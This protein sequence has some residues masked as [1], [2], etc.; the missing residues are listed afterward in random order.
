MKRYSIANGELPGGCILDPY[1]IHKHV[2][3][4]KRGNRK[5]ETLA[6][7]HKVQ[8][9]NA[10]TSKDDAL[11]AE[12]LLV[13]LTERFPAVLDVDAAARTSSRCSGRAAGRRFQ[14]WLR[15]KPGKENEV[16][17]GRWPVRR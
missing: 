4:R 13:K 11:A 5:L 1:I 17:D 8:L 10:H 14:A 6:V 7:E 2:I 16:I 12:R 15:T 9:D 3:P